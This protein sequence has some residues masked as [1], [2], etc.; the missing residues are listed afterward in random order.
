VLIDCPPS[1]GANARAALV[2]ADLALIV[3]EP[4]SY[5]LRG[6]TAVLDLIDDVWDR[7]NPELDFAGVVVNKMPG[8]SGEADRRTDEL[9]EMVG[10]KAVWKPPIPNRVIVNQAHGEQQPIHSYG[11]RARVVLDALDALYAKLR[12]AAQ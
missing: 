1:H 10:R 12:R 11:Y 9:I 5:S 2:A 3:V 4:A 8:V 7:S 6:V